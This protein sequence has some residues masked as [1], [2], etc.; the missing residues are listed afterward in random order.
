MLIQSRSKLR[1]LF[2]EYF[3]RGFCLG[4]GLTY[5]ELILRVQFTMSMQVKVETFMIDHLRHFALNLEKYKE[6]Q[7]FPM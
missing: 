2:V 4:D 7:D 1:S 5:S 6:V 3:W